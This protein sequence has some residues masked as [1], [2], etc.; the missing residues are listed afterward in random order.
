MWEPKVS[1]NVNYMVLIVKSKSPTSA[2]YYSDMNMERERMPIISQ[3]NGHSTIH[4]KNAEQFQIA[5][6]RKYAVILV[7]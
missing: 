4:R 2:K 5:D 7:T 6:S 1:V 3:K